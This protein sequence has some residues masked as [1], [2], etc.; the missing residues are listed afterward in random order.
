MASLWL[1]DNL[2]HQRH[3]L[4]VDTQQ[5]SLMLIITAFSSMKFSTWFN[6]PSG[7]SLVNIIPTFRLDPQYGTAQ[8]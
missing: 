6:N 5:S 1:G 4:I 8:A 3:G 7:T 2:A